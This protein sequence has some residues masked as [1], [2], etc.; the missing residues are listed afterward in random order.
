MQINT[1]KTFIKKQKTIKTEI[2]EL[3]IIYKNKM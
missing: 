2:T 3:I 1:L